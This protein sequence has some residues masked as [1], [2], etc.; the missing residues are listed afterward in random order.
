MSDSSNNKSKLTPGE[1]AD[2][3]NDIIKKQEN[4]L[5]DPLAF[6]FRKINNLKVVTVL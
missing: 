4:D 3:M 6:R 2:H 5:R 1:G